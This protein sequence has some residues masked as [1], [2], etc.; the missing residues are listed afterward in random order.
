MPTLLVI[1]V[2]SFRELYEIPVVFV[3]SVEIWVC[4]FV[5]LLATVPDNELNDAFVDV[6]FDDNELSCDW[7]FEEI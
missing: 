6:I 3:W 2:V 5:L 1:S 7:T 4:K